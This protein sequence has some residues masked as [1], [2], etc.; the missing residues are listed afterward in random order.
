MSILI[1]LIGNGW[2]IIFFI[3]VRFMSRRK[4]LMRK[5]L[6]GHCLLQ[7]LCSFKI[8]TGSEIHLDV[9]FIGLVRAV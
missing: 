2:R 8:Q 7:I 4:S 5:L 3:L 6:V 9:N 1:C